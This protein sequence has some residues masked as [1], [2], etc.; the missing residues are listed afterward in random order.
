VT[1]DGTL[2]GPGTGDNAAAA[3]G[4]NLSP[5]DVILSIGSSGVVAALHDRP[6]AD[7]TGM[8]AGFADA[9]GAF[10]PLACTLN[11]AR[12][13]DATAT[14]LGVTLDSLT[15][16]ALAAPPGSDGLVLVPYLEGERT[17]SRPDST[18]AVHGLTQRTATPHDLARAAIEGI[19][20]GFADALDALR[21]IGAPARRVLLIGGG[22]KSTAVQ[23]IAPTVLDAQV[24]VPTSAEYVARGAARQAAWVLS[25]ADEPPQWSAPVAAEFAPEPHSAIRERYADVARLTSRR[26]DL[27]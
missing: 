12:V 17:P 13:L 10:L 2:V 8:I 4:L 19:L 27:S 23:R 22:A 11:A 9:T 24:V 16:L 7:P 15:N 3:L 1:A 21:D 20:C 25:Q 14:I 18:G 26:R 5:G 6:V